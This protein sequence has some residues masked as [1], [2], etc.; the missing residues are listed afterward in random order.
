VDPEYVPLTLR[1]AARKDLEPELHKFKQDLFSI[2]GQNVD[3]TYDLRGLRNVLLAPENKDRFSR[4]Y[5]RQDGALD[6]AMPREIAYYIRC[7]INKLKAL[8]FDQDSLYR[9]EWIAASPK[10]LLFEVVP[11]LETVGLECSFRVN[12][13]VTDILIER[14]L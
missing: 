11:K 5:F 12:Y 13:H 7:A 14:S 10:G 4:R 1:R 9:N 6:D 3:I 8:G 2:F